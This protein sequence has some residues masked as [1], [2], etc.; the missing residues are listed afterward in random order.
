MGRGISLNRSSI[1]SI[2]KC[3]RPPTGPPYPVLSRSPKIIRS[4]FDARESIYDLSIVPGQLA[5]YRPL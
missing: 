5:I 1:R 2:D 4:I 3:D